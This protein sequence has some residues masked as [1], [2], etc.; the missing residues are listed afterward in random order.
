MAIEPFQQAAWDALNGPAR[1]VL[2]YGGSRSGKT[3]TIVQ[4]LVLRALGKPGSSQAIYRHRFNALRGSIIDGPTATLP[5]V[6]GTRWPGQK[7]YELDRTEWCAV[8]KNGSRIYF[9]GLD[10]KERS[11]KVLGQEHCA[12]YLNECS[13]ISYAARLIASTRISQS[14]GLKL[15]LVCDCN[16]PA[17]GHW[18][19]R[20]FIG[21]VDPLSKAAIP[22][23]EQ[24]VHV[25]MNPAQSPHLDEEYKRALS[26]Y[27][28]RMRERF[29]LGQYGTAT[30]GSLWTVD[31][32]AAA[33]VAAIPAGVT[34]Q[35]IV[36]AIDPSGCH[37]PEDKRSDEVGMVVLGLGTDGVV[38]VLEDAS[39]RFG[40]DGPE[41]WGARAIERC[42]HWGV[43]CIYGESNFGGAM[44]GAVVKTAR[45]E[46]SPGVFVEG[47]S[48]GFREISAQRGKSVRAE[49]VGTLTTGGGLK[50]VGEF[51]E[52]EDQLV[53]FTTAGYEG[54]RSPDRA[55]AMVHGGYAL[56]VVQMPGAGFA[57]F[58]A[59]EAA[60]VRADRAA[61]TEP[62][63]P[64]PDSL[65][66][67]RA[68]PAFAG[69]CQ[70]QCTSGRNYYVD[71]GLLQADPRDLKLLTAAGFVA[72]PSPP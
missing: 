15:K 6:C 22:D 32:I 18:T 63:A 57:N 60:K 65:V 9:G 24:Y 19:E 41:G 66:T 69:P 2:L 53:Q 7:L 71:G 14:V 16:P 59:E 5:K 4:W 48:I 11:E 31:T 46:R 43:D 36:L 10:S 37:G 33:R 61:P 3:H 13:Q 29:W 39:G 47:R 50:F 1:N 64:P 51:P 62:A 38:Y 40:P 49:P 30:A 34:L 58:V 20:A 72:V 26:N 25:Q 23:P 54:D 44:V 45:Y 35:R 67:M 8:F 17:V 55:D 42:L 21:H 56:G 28:G 52:L 12:V 27:T 70:Y 68:P